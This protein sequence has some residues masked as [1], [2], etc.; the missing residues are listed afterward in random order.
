MAQREKRKANGIQIQETLF[1]LLQIHVWFSFQGNLY[2]LLVAKEAAKKYDN[3][4]ER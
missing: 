2:C 1:F 4:N 3:H